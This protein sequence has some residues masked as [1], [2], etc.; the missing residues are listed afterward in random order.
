MSHR[1]LVTRD[2]QDTDVLPAVLTFLWLIRIAAGALV[3]HSTQAAAVIFVV[4]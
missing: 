1:L 3:L 2:V 4:L